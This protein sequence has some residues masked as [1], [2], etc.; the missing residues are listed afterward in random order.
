MLVDLGGVAIRVAGRDDLIRM[1]A[2]AA[3][4][5]DLSDIAAL[6]ADDADGP[7]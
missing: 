5:Q 3:R 2:A 1:K 6:T 7:G 4:P